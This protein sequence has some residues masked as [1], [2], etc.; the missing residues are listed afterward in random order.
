V[1]RAFRCTDVLGTRIGEPMHHER[2]CPRFDE[3]AQV[4]APAAST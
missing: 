3:K 2:S 1:S 4:V